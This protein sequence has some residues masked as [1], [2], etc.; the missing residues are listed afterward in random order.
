MTDRTKI[1]K[2]RLLTPVNFLAPKSYDI[3]L[4]VVSKTKEFSNG[5]RV[6]P[7][8][9]GTWTIG[10]GVEAE[11]GNEKEEIEGIR[12]SIKRG[13]NHIDTAQMY[14]AGHTEEIVGRAIKGFNRKKLFIAS[15][16][17][18]THATRKKIPQAIEG[19]LKRLQTAYL[20]LLYI[21]AC[22]DEEMIGEY[23]AGLNDAKEKGL[24]KAIGVSNFDIDQ[25]RKA[26]SVS[27]NP[28]IANQ[29][30]YNVLY[31][32]EVPGEMKRY[33]KKEKI[34]IVAYR[35]VE[36]GLLADQCENKTVLALAKKYRKTPAQIAINWL[37]SQENVVTIPKSIDKKHI[38]ENLGAVDFELDSEDVQKLNKLG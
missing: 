5:A 17:W 22:W 12:Y 14:G 23:L 35:P 30:N 31:Q 36:R 2:Y 21:H 24:T 33:C 9:I 38:D 18:Q 37:I 8:G 27:K 7:V 6:Y 28:I 32:V 4:T 3:I 29:M 11:Y 10:G 19:I 13:Q 26:V 25:L 15:K 16:V 34:M 1:I 20:D